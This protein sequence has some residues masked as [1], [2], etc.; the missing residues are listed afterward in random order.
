MCPTRANRV[1]KKNGMPVNRNGSLFWYRDG[2]LHREDGPAVIKPDGSQFWKRDGQLHREDGPAEIW[3]DG[4][5]RWY[6]NNRLHRED[7]PAEIRPD[8]T[9]RWALHVGDYSVQMIGATLSTGYDKFD[10]ADPDSPD[11]IRKHL[12]RL[13]IKPVSWLADL[14]K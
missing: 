14:L 6:R 2:E 9:Q 11:Q 4:T 12:S 1:V 13:K 3:A 8:G 7:G 10:L 5:R